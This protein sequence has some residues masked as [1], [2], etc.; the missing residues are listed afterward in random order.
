M[1][2]GYVTQTQFYFFTNKKVQTPYDLAGQKTA[3]GGI[4]VAFMQALGVT[5]VTMALS[6]MYGAMERGVINGFNYPFAAGFSTTW[7]LQEVTKYVI[8]HPYYVG[9]TVLTMNLNKWNSLPKNLQDLMKEVTSQ[10]ETETPGIFAEL[11]TKERDMAVKA[12]LQAIKF[13]SADAEWYNRIA[14]EAAWKDVID[15]LPDVGRRLKDLLTK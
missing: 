2:R 1:G 8:D 5:P 7:H 4:H 13:S 9:D 14:Y 10:V 6:E 12:G 3:P 15:K 11:N